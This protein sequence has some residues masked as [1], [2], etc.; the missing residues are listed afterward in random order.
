MKDF[1]P[2]FNGL[3]DWKKSK[4]R[5]LFLDPVETL[6]NRK[7][8]R[9][10]AHGRNFHVEGVGG[11]LFEPRLPVDV[12]ETLRSL[13]PVGRHIPKHL[14]I[15]LKG[16]DKPR[17]TV[18]LEVGYKRLISFYR[19]TSKIQKFLYH[20]HS[21]A[22]V[23]L[24]KSNLG[25][26]ISLESLRVV[27]FEQTLKTCNV[28]NGVPRPVVNR[29]KANVARLDC[30]RTVLDGVAMCY[31]EILKHRRSIPSKGISSLNRLKDDC[32]RRPWESAA[33]VKTLATECR[34]YYFGGPAP[35][36]PLVAWMNAGEALTFSY[37]ARSMPSPILTKV[38]KNRLLT[39]LG[40]RLTQPPPVEPPDWRSF[41]RGWLR[42]RRGNNPLSLL[43]EPSVSAALGYSGERWGHSG[44]Y[45]DIWVFQL[46]TQL[47]RGT[48]RPYLLE[49]VRVGGQVQSFGMMDAMFLGDIR[50]AKV[51]NILLMDGCETILDLI[52]ENGWSL[53]AVPL[54]APEK[55]LKVRVPTLGLTAANLVQ[56]AFRKAAD[57][58]LLNDPRSSKSLGGDLDQDLGGEEGGW[59]S[60]D[61]TLRLTSTAF[62]RSAYS[63]KKF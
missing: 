55:G 33:L 15:I 47:S 39:E 26:G 1:Y 18:S 45:R 54:T 48:L 10:V 60:Q 52:L 44:A 41:I 56:Q 2:S 19:I 16:V 35:A 59:Y 13:V 37:L 29:Y 6:A 4:I 8:L 49:T 28:V 46:G 23:D 31:H 53:P 24:L 17:R 32:W 14:G 9:L 42:T 34:A 27:D 5:H 62:G 43:A 63:M 38:D 25:V 21:A 51:M 7:G 22:A 3:C 50:V 11:S 36:H 12:R 58:F 20:F 61:L 57:H 30:M 40:T